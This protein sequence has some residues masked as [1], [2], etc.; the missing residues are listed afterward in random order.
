MSEQSTVSAVETSA[1]CRLAF[2]EV[3][4]EL[5]ALPDAEKTVVN[6]DVHQAASLAVGVM[7][8]V[9]TLRDRIEASFK[10]FDFS[11]LDKL[12]TFARAAM[13]TQTMHE[14]A[15]QPPTALEPVVAEAGVLRDALHDAADYLDKRG[16]VQ[17]DGLAD[18]KSTVGYKQLSADL[19]K[20]CAFV[21]A[22]SALFFQKTALDE[23]TLA[24]AE[25][26]A[27]ALFTAL[28]LRDNA[29]VAIAEAQDLRQRAFTVFARAYE[30]VRRAVMY[31]RADEPDADTFMPSLYAGRGG[32]RRRVVDDAPAQ[33]SA[34]ES[35]PKAPPGE[36]EMTDSPFME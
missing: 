4:A 23:A 35:K 15:E 26:V 28:A 3:E 33:V 25:V 10:A 24:R 5:R 32:S 1:Q 30:Q 34:S 20:L 14:L 7:P 6:V 9:L 17:A 19:F 18:V 8:R 11:R 36:V 12:G 27:N 29:P 31:V 16:V 2:Q 22:H 21:R 13:H